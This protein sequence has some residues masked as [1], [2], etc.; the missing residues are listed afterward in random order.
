MKWGEILYRRGDYL[1]A[2]GQFGIIAEKFPDSPLA[3]KAIFLSAQAM[4]RSLESV[5]NGGGHRSL[6]AGGQV[7]RPAFSASH[8][9]RK[10]AF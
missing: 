6:R 2:R 1:S 10:P 7:R 4:A 9:S 3:E 5:R 8:G